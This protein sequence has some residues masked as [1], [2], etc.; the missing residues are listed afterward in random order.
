MI[1]ALLGHLGTTN[2]WCF[3]VGAADGV[4]YSNTKYF[5]DQGWSAVLIES[6]DEKFAK[7][8]EHGSPRVRCIRQK[9]E[10]NDLDILLA[11]AGAPRDMD[12]GVIDIDGQDWWVWKGMAMYRPRVMLAE[13]AAGKMDAPIPPE[14][15]APGQ[16]GLKQIVE[17]GESK[18]YVA[19]ARTECNVLFCCRTAANGRL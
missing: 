16:A 7:L 4:W 18:G 5:R 12:L 9:I 6:D 8:A 13:Y 3:E 14:G 1:G 11:R 15:A 10:G 19:V 2:R 17:L